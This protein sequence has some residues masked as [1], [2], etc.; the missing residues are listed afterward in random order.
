MVV[1]ASEGFKRVLEGLGGTRVLVCQKGLGGSWR[2]SNSLGG[3]RKVLESLLWSRKVKVQRES[4]KVLNGLKILENL[5]ESWMVYWG[6]GRVLNG[7]G[8][9]RRVS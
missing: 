9:S 8:G 6:L 2:I 4:R 5:G 1:E 3:Y 7:M